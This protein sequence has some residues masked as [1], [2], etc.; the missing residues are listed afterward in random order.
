M[1][2]A[3]SRTEQIISSDP[4]DSTFQL[5]FLA[6]L[7]GY[8]DPYQ[9]LFPDQ[10][11]FR[12]FAQAVKG[13]IA[14]SVPIVTRMAAAVLQ[15]RDPRRTFHVA[16]RFYR[17]LE[18]PRLH[19]RDLLKPAYAQ[20]RSLFQDEEEPY[21]P[22]LLDFTNLE[23]PYGY[24]FEALSTLKASG[25]RTGPRCREG[26]VPGYNQLVALALGKDKV[27]LTFAKTISY[28]TKDF[29]SLNREI[30]RAIRYS[31]VVLQGRK[32]RVICDRGFDDEK[33]FAFVVS[34]DEEFV[35][36]L[37]HDRLLRLPQGEGWQEQS[38]QEIV[39]HLPRPLRFEAR[40][41]IRGRWRKSLVTLGY[42][43]VWLPGHQHPYWLVVSEVYGL[44][45]RWVLLT[46]V[47][48]TSLE[49]AR[50]IWDNYRRRWRVE[51]TFRFL[52]REGLRWDDFKVLSL[53]A[54]RRLINVVLIAAL[55]LLNWHLYL[56]ET[57]HQLLLLLGGK[58]GLKSERDG[59]Y[60]ALRGW[61][62]LLACLATL[63]VLKR[64]GK[65]DSLLQALD[66]L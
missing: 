16:K 65:L 11:L 52:Q 43:Q 24:R 9:A 19:H 40:F 53:E 35:I 56:D 63:A 28:V 5:S 1:V 49:Q 2:E 31:H 6:Q 27:G 22:V 21:I 3:L 37:Y 45:Q 32:I 58:Q 39:R 12:R 7:R 30:F 50:E 25:L 8:L 48:V 61:Q 51:E 57:A 36:R 29:V 55:F 13:I 46:N 59:L 47:P 4:V 20:T 41:K 18:N 38:L 64:Y 62:K 14:A 54:I 60:L 44:S 42:C 15:S 26:M 10:R 66:A 34:L 23:K 33:T 17:W